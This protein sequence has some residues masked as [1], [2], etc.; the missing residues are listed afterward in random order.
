MKED[1][2]ERK[3]AEALSKDIQWMRSHQVGTDVF[4]PFDPLVNAKIEAAYDEKKAV[5]VMADDKHRYKIDFRSMT[6][7][8]MSG[9]DIADVQR[10]DRRG[11]LR[12]RKIFSRTSVYTVL[13]EL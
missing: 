11:K 1:E 8:D 4:A 3:R 7:K 5:V 13:S 12:G 9:I 6:A 2:N 10:V